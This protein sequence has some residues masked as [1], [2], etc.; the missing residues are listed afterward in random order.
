MVCPIAR[1]KRRA[2]FDKLSMRFFLNATK[3]LP[4][5]EPVEG[6]TAFVQHAGWAY[7]VKSTRSRII[8]SVRRR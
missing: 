1:D 2:C 7:P 5:P 8:C 6:R 3:S 4:H